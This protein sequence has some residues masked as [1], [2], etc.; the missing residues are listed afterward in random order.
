MVICNS[1]EV[2]IYNLRVLDTAYSLILNKDN[3]PIFTCRAWFIWISSLEIFIGNALNKHKVLL[4]DAH[5][6][7]KKNK[8]CMLLMTQFH[9]HRNKWAHEWYIHSPKNFSIHL[10]LTLFMSFIFLIFFFNFLISLFFHWKRG[11]RHI[12]N[13]KT[14][15]WETIPIQ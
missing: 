3:P 7:T 1:S 13:M 8:V 10:I 15:N 12:H 4:S 9:L 2:L 6:R 11:K 14:Q 5:F